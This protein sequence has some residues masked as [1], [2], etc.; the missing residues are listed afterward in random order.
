MRRLKDFKTLV[1][2][3]FIDF[4]G[5]SSHVV[6]IDRMYCPWLA[7]TIIICVGTCLL[8]SHDKRSYVWHGCVIQRNERKITAAILRRQ[9]IVSPRLFP[10]CQMPGRHVRDRH[11]PESPDTVGQCEDVKHRVCQHAR[12]IVHRDS[13]ATPGPDRGPSESSGGRAS[14]KRVEEMLLR[15]LR[16]QRRPRVCPRGTE[17][18]Q[19]HHARCLAN[20]RPT[21][22]ADYHIDYVRAGLELP[23]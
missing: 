19:L 7:A 8:P 14:I 9:D 3:R 17:Q 16:V 23:R 1:S 13:S 18:V 21:S 4:T 10:T 5:N 2:I 22:A 11:T 12:A 15:R 20:N 6:K